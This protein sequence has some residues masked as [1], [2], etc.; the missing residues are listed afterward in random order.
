MTEFTLIYHIELQPL[1]NKRDVGYIFSYSDFDISMA[2]YVEGNSLFFGVPKRSRLGIPVAH[3]FDECVKIPATFNKPVAMFF[4]YSYE[5][6]R[7]TLRVHTGRTCLGNI[8]FD[9]DSIETKVHHKFHRVGCSSDD[10][11]FGH[12][13]LYE[14]LAYA[15]LFT[16]DETSNLVSYF[17]KK[18][19]KANYLEFNG[20]QYMSM[21]LKS[22]ALVQP[23]DKFKPTLRFAR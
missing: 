22:G 6:K 4:G 18:R 13:R 11:N 21:D 15:Q 2:A 20:N 3:E 19:N 10:D 7:V 9:S 23:D 8:N 5:D 1:P 14:S 12:F 16:D 17:D